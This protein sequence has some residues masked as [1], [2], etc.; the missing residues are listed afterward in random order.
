MHVKAEGEAI[1]NEIKKRGVM[2]DRN[3]GRERI[4]MRVGDILVVYNSLR[5]P[6]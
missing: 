4:Q 3:K 1:M 5:I 2:I 6:S